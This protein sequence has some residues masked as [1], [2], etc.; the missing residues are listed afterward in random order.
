MSPAR[1]IPPPEPDL[2]PVEDRLRR[3]DF[4]PDEA[5]RASLRASLRARRERALR[6]RA[7][8][9]RL[10]N[11]FAA[12]IGLALLLAVGWGLHWS[13]N[14]GLP[15]AAG[16]TPAP[17]ETS[18]PA[19]ASPTPDLPAPQPTSTSKTEE[20]TEIPWN[21]PLTLQTPPE[22]ILVY[23]VTAPQKDTWVEGRLLVPTGGGA[24]D[25]TV[26][27]QAVL[28]PSGTGRVLLS[29]TVEDAGPT[30]PATLPPAE[31]RYTEGGALRRMALPS[32]EMLPADNVDF[33]PLY[34]L[35]PVGPWIFPPE[36]H[37]AS[38]HLE[39][40]GTEHL[41]GRDALIV[42]VSASD[43][44]TPRPVLLSKYWVDADTGLIL[45]LQFFGQRSGSG[46]SVLVGEWIADTFRDD[47]PLSE[48]LL[49]PASP[50]A[51]FLVSPLGEHPS[52]DIAPLWTPQGEKSP[53]CSGEDC[54]RAP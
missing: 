18:S 43:M 22:D 39:T 14:H 38:A 35:P 48:D 1:R 45:R 44:T 28:R 26:F 37:P 31:L 54:L 40:L 7:M 27:L 12:V 53:S 33:P 11:T 34:S 29:E 13:L 42:Q 30:R 3:A 15:A 10:R 50:P 5:F 21:H 49:S 16:S 23:G 2:R 20:A 46:E 17:T 4:A 9:L 51:D 41:A 36:T 52:P 6:K 32:G 47:A 19:P 8:Y 25:L 24:P